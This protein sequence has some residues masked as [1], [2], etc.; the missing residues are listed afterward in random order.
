MEAEGVLE[1]Q[2]RLRAAKAAAAIDP[3]NPNPEDDDLPPNKRRGHVGGTAPPV[4]A[5]GGSGKGYMSPGDVL[6]H[7][8]AM[9]AAGAAS[10]ASSTGGQRTKASA[11]VSRTA[12]RTKILAQHVHRAA[13]HG[14][15][16]KSACFLICSTSTACWLV[17]SL[18]GTRCYRVRLQPASRGA[19][20]G[21]HTNILLLIVGC[22]CRK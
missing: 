7:N 21:T 12:V 19:S 10:A 22:I 4:A 2:R 13:N 1:K 18:L 8:A 20:P 3:L 14:N 17:L 5:G 15:M 16:E 9:K 6:R 11:P